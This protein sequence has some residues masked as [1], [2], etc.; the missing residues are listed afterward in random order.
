M[1]ITVT[2][3]PEGKLK[4]WF[5]W[6]MDYIVRVVGKTYDGLEGGN[7]FLTCLQNEMTWKQPAL[8]TVQRFSPHVHLQISNLSFFPSICVRPKQTLSKLVVSSRYKTSST[9]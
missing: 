6:H 7:L 3:R 5:S 8:F 2:T 4:T 1:Y 9:M